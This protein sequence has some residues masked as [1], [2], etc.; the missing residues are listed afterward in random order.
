MSPPTPTVAPTVPPVVAPVA[1]YLRHRSNKSAGVILID[2][3]AENYLDPS[4]YR[5]MVVQQKGSGIWGLPKGHLEDDETLHQA[6]VREMREET[7]VDLVE[8]LRE[9]VD[10]LS[11]ALKVV[12]EEGTSDALFANHVQI[13]KIHFFAYVLLRSGQSLVPAP[14]DSHEIV[15]V[16]WLHVQ[17]WDIDALLEQAYVTGRH[18]AP[19]KFNRTLSDGAVL[20]LQEAA[21]KAA[22]NIAAQHPDPGGP[23]HTVFG[24]HHPCDHLF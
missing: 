4:T 5:V 15:R 21:R 9:H 20:T 6:A 14:V 11:V 17:R 23:G 18:V 13:K 16:S 7:G 8:G 3:W 12:V 2:P 19:P 24:W 10:Y 22:R 1:P